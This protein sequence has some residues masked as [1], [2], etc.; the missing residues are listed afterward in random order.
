MPPVIIF[1][2][3]LGSVIHP[4]M[5]L[6]YTHKAYFLKASEQYHIQRQNLPL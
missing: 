5:K 4:D 2:A 6:V 1:S 3:S